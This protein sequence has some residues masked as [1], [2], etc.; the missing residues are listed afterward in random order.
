VEANLRASKHHT[1]TVRKEREQLG[2]QRNVGKSSY[3]SG[4]GTGQMAQPL[5]FMMMKNTI[6]EEVTA[7]DNRV[8]DTKR[9]S[10]D[11]LE[12]CRRDG[13]KYLMDVPFKKENM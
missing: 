12:Q 11:R 4:D 2:D 1:T 10:R 5:M 9:T 8:R 13:G 7:T 3:N 6:K